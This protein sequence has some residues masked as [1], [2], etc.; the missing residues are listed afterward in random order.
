MRD[1]DIDHGRVD[2]GQSLRIGGKQ[3]LQC[4]RGKR[5]GLPRIVNHAFPSDDTGV[6]ARLDKFRGR[7]GRQHGDLLRERGPADLQ[8]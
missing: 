5:H 1:P 2:P 3:R 8:S 6:D 4:G 7:L